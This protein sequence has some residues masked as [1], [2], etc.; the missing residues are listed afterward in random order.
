MIQYESCSIWGS[1]EIIHRREKWN[2]KKSINQKIRS[3]RKR[4][5]KQVE[6]IENKKIWDVNTNIAVITL[7]INGLSIQIRS[8]K[9]SDWI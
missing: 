6:K 5:T 1:K 2:N 7:N 4:N 3:E 9:L 8:H